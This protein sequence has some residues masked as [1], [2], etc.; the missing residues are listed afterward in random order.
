MELCV[1]NQDTFPEL[2]SATVNAVR[3]GKLYFVHDGRN[4]WWSTWVQRYEVNCM[5]ISLERAKQYA[6]RQRVQG[7]VFYVNEIPALLVQ[8]GSL[9]LAVT[10]INCSN[11]LSGYS[12][13]AVTEVL[14]PGFEKLENAR[15]N[16]LEQGSPMIGTYLS[17]APESRFWCERPVSQHIVRVVCRSTLEAFQPL[18]LPLKSHKSHSSGPRY[19]LG[20]TERYRSES[21]M[22]LAALAKAGNS[23][24]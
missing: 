7:S 24:R 22:A 8:G 23:D 17:F 4:A 13:D 12:A 5:H 6:E 9:V 10:Q 16:Y 21:A 18:V 20:W 1:Y 19:L 15:N 11:A 3:G 14:P 2:G